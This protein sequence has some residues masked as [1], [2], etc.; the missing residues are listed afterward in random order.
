MECLK[1]EVMNFFMKIR[2]LAINATTEIVSRFHNNILCHMFGIGS[3]KA[4]GENGGPPNVEAKCT[5]EFNI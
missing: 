2:F 3:L 5:K 1:A 4:S